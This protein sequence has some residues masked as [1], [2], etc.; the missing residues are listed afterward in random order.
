MKIQYEQLPIP[1]IDQP[2]FIKGY[3]YGEGNIYTGEISF[4]NNMDKEEI[5]YPPNTTDLRPPIIPE[6]QDAIYDTLFRK[7][8]LVQKPPKA[9]NPHEKI[10]VL[11]EPPQLPIF[12][13]QS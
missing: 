2:A 10:E 11:P 5:H 3:Q 13:A 8:N 7:W 9:P 6:G 1:K 12:E 4:H